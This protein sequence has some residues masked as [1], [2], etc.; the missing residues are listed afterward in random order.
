MR[1]SV[2]IPVYNTEQYLN[3]CI[4]S[5]LTQS[6]NDFELLLIDD[7]STDGS[8]AICDLYAEKDSRVRVFHKENGGV[9]SAR[10]LGLDNAK[11]EWIYFVDSDDEL[12]HDGLLTLANCVSDEV[13]IVMGGFVEIGEDGEKTFSVDER[14]ELLLSKEQS[15]ITLYFG[16]GLYYSYLGYMC[17]RLF[18]NDVI[19]N[20]RLR[21]DIS[22]A[23]KED[24][25]FTM[26]YIC[27]SNGITRQTTTPVYI[28]YLRSGSAMGKTRNSFDEKYLDS[29]YAL[30]KMK[31]EV[32]R[33][34]PFFS[35]AVFVADQGIFGRYYEIIDKM[36]RFGVENAKTELMLRKMMK[37]EI[38]SVIWYKVRRK[39]RKIIRKV[40]NKE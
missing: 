38:G 7:G 2:I 17:L 28:Y 9:S 36:K 5:I 21:F 15:V 35:E 1:I 29:F 39:L 40:L 10:N 8:G 34:F 3:R 30:V 11:G 14:V 18:R 12:L 16:H 33:V 6:F 20:H 19:R 37:R 4:D 32:K 22:I 13:D 31:H 27:K 25:L 26:Q 23:I 24:T